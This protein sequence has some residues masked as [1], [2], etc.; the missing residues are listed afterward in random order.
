MPAPRE[1][2]YVQLADRFGG[3][4]GDYRRRAAADLHEWVSLLGVEG[5]AGQAW[6][7]LGPDDEVYRSDEDD[8]W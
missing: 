8:D 4:P 6:L 2:L 7:G 5:R 1:W 3:W